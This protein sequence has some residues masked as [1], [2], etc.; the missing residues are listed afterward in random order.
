MVG[1]TEANAMV[2]GDPT[3]ADGGIV[4]RGLSGGDGEGRWA[5]AMRSEDAA[6]VITY[7]QEM[8]YLADDP[9]W[10]PDKDF[11][12]FP[13]STESSRDEYV[14]RLKSF[15]GGYEY[16]TDF[17]DLCPRADAVKRRRRG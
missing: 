3:S 17:G 4:C 9:N 11:A 15:L 10:G 14:G 5:W 2:I 12:L 6:V 16:L 8:W 7:V 1:V 13:L